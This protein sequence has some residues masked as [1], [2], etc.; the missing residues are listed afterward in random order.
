MTW[1][2]T[3]MRGCQKRAS[4]R[5]AQI[6]LAVLGSVRLRVVGVGQADE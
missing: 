6:D 4:T 2:V 3:I 1:T 5:A